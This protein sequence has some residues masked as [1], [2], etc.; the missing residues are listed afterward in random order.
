MQTLEEVEEHSDRALSFR[1]RQF[2]AFFHSVWHTDAHYRVIVENWEFE[3]VNRFPLSV[4]GRR[5]REPSAH[6]N[7]GCETSRSGRS[8]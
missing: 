7:V 3:R 2:V 8:F 5:F 1:E 6:I 4:I